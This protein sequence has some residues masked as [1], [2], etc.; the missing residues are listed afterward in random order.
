MHGDG[1]N[2]CACSRHPG[3]L[4]A[5]NANVQRLTRIFCEVLARGAT[6]FLNADV[7]RRIVQAIQMLASIDSSI[8]SLIPPEVQ[9]H[10]S[11]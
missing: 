10:L 5:G 8:L 7:K 9:P 4:G 11:A 3:V 2:L 6:D 1:S